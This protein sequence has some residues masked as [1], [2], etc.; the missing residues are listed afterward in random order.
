MIVGSPA[1]EVICGLGGNDHLD[2]ERGVD[3]LSGGPGKDCLV[4][5]DGGR[6]TVD[7]GPGRDYPLVDP[8]LD[9]LVSVEKSY[10]K[11]PK[12]NSPCR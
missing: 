2:G 5:R 1:A 10:T 4:A 9:K 11:W 3:T 8:T 7:G 12:K 6:D